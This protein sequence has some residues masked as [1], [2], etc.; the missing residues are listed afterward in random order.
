M[1]RQIPKDLP[2]DKVES[3]IKELEDLLGLNWLNRSSQKENK[4]K[5]IW[6]RRD[7][8]ATIE[9]YTLGNAIK[10]IDDNEW[11]EDFCKQVKSPKESNQVGAIFEAVA[12]SMFSD[13][14]EA[15]LAPPGQPGYDFSVSF[16]ERKLY[17]SCK[18]LQNSDEYKKLRTEF[19]FIESYFSS[20]LKKLRLTGKQLF[21]YSHT[22][23][24]LPKRYKLKKY[25]D[26][27]LTLNAKEIHRD[28][29]SFL[30]KNIESDVE[31]FSLSKFESSYLVNF[32]S[33]YKENEQSRYEQLFKSATR[34][35]SKHSPVK[36]GISANA[37]MINLPESVSI[38]SATKWT[39]KKFKSDGSKIA[40]VILVRLLPAVMKEKNVTQTVIEVGLVINHHS[41]SQLLDFIDYKNGEMFKLTLP[42]GT[43]VNGDLEKVIGSEQGYLDIND[44]YSFQKGHISYQANNEGPV[45]FN[46]NAQP[47]ISYDALV[48]PNP[49]SGYV[50]IEMIRPPEDEFIAI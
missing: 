7:F 47:N 48:R 6:R 33:R 41:N 21:I 12:F 14:H 35:I 50:K 29:H 19:D 27:L 11:L 28:K 13:N 18:R 17:I 3:S 38:E 40:F 37:I 39:E 4:I 43:F 34:N 16:D 10:M 15:E 49:E 30:I 5:K 44:F 46:L 9:L 22:A 32:V 36:S 8:L 20:E 42:V 1:N 26:E 25:I 24:S 23:S 45:E 31:G 2:K